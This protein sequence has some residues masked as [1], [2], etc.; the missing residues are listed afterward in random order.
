[1]LNHRTVLVVEDEPLIAM[2][3]SLAIEDAGGQVVGPVPTVGEAITLL[4]SRE[5]ASAI[6]DANLIDRD[7]TPVALLLASRQVPFVIHTAVGVPSELSVALPGV[8]VV[9][10]PEAPEQVLSLLIDEIQKG[11]Q[12]AYCGYSGRSI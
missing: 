10:K 11:E 1:M 7:I 6:L 3:L 8:P 2:S 9:M 5:V 4:T 12:K